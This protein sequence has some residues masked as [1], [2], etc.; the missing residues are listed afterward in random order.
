MK[1]KDAKKKKGFTSPRKD[2]ER[3]KERTRRTR[4]PS[5]ANGRLDETE[6]TEYKDAEGRESLSERTVV[7]TLHGVYQSLKIWRLR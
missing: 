3:E 2:Y 5:K 6:T 7:A 4:E 1:E